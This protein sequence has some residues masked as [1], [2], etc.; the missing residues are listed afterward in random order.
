VADVLISCWRV[1]LY[2]VDRAAEM[3][4]GLLLMLS[5][6]V[7][8]PSAVAAAANVTSSPHDDSLYLNH[9]EN[10][11]A[12]VWEGSP[13]ADW[14]VA[15]IVIA[16]GILVVGT[17]IGNVLVVTAVGVVRRLRT[18]SNL[19]IVSLATADLLVALLDMPFAALYEVNWPI[20]HHHSDTPL[21]CTVI[22]LA[23]SKF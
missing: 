19:L 3:T 20:D 21:H 17:V 14:Q 11:T 22:E 15:L 13:Y 10:T 5:G 9:T 23:I 6:A 1:G 16:C 12:D 2:S 4:L 18:P 8:L 7:Q